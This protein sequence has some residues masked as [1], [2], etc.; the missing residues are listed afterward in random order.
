M[1][2]NIN[3]RI[4][5]ENL[6]NEHGDFTFNILRP[7]IL[8]KKKCQRMEISRDNFAATVGNFCELLQTCD[9]YAIDEE[10]TGISL[11]EQP[12]DPTMSVEATYDIKRRVAK[13]YSII[14]VGICLFHKNHFSPLFLTFLKVSILQFLF[15]HFIIVI[16][17]SFNPALS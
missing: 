17:N 13:K 8:P 16:F 10:M 12:E 4:C 14:Q 1:C 3:S 11:V 7:L 2:H 9:F 5:L 6:P 15:Y